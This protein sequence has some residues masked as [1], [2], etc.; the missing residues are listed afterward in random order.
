MEK[1]KS[2]KVNIMGLGFIASDSLPDFPD[3]Q[4]LDSK[5]QKIVVV[6]KDKYKIEFKDEK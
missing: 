2:E 5:I 6:K 3:L 1:K 4:I